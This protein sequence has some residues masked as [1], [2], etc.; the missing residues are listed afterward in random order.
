M[1]FP[2]ENENQSII[3]EFGDFIRYTDYK[4]GDISDKIK[5]LALNVPLN[6]IYEGKISPLILTIYYNYCNVFNI[7]LSRGFDI[8]ASDDMFNNMNP[9]MWA[10]EKNNEYI[11]ERLLSFEHID[12][13]FRNK[14]NEN[15]LFFMG[16]NMTNLSLF[17]RIIDMMIKKD[18]D[19]FMSYLC[20]NKNKDCD[21]YEQTKTPIHSCIQYLNQFDDS[22]K[23]GKYHTDLTLQKIKI[24]LNILYKYDKDSVKYYNE[25]MFDFIKLEHFF[26]INYNYKYITFCLYEYFKEIGINRKIKAGI[27]WCVYHNNIYLLYQ[28]L[29]DGY[30]INEYSDSCGT[31]L[32]LAV[33]RSNYNMVKY[34]IGLGS[35]KFNYLENYDELNLAIENDDLEMVKLLEEYDYS[36]TYE[37]TNTIDKFNVP[38]YY[39]PL[40]IAILC[41]SINCAKYIIAKTGDD[42]SFPGN[43]SK[44]PL[45]LGLEK[46]TN[47]NYL[48]ILQSNKLDYHKFHKK[49]S[50]KHTECCICL[51][52]IS[53]SDIYVSSCGHAFHEHCILT[54]MKN[55]NSCPYCRTDL[56][57]HNL[58][59]VRLCDYKFEKPDKSKNKR[60]RSKSLSEIDE[61]YL[62]FK[63]L[64]L[65]K[66]DLDNY[67]IDDTD[68]QKIKFKKLKQKFEEKDRSR[69]IEQLRKYLHSLKCFKNIRRPKTKTYN[70]P[71][72]K[73]YKPSLNRELKKLEC[74]YNQN[75]ELKRADR[76]NRGQR[77]NM[78]INEG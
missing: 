13:F 69:K 49:Y 25:F 58:Y 55:T 70:T 44:S 74:F 32:T 48:E 54:N 11:I 50:N 38:K 12:L 71:I 22:I 2:K 10:I 72:L 61:Q 75:T 8:N 64:R 19:K 3:K 43:C 67:N 17:Q 57:L 78:Y 73:E 46:N 15:I 7:L 66:L 62:I 52:S 42:I 28:F 5:T 18:E 26:E 1:S 36:L 41:G 4:D 27:S 65:D 53:S 45:S 16:I 30:D 63:D 9:L 34:L 29:N 23:D 20:S 37:Y 6:S 21:K 31:A 24:Y 77:E 35:S 47:I 76:R 39:R 68:Y 56:E 40:H 14:Y 59:K 60:K 51:D 33:L